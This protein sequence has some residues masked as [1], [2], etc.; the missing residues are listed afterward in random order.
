MLLN[1]PSFAPEISP[2]VEFGG[3]TDRHLSLALTMV[4]RGSVDSADLSA[5]SPENVN[6]PVLR[7]LIDTAWQREVGDVF[8]FDILSVA[9]TL[10]IVGDDKPDDDL[11]DDNGKP[12]LGLYI[13]CNMPESIMPGEA[14]EAV[15]AAMPGLGRAALEIIEQALQPFGMPFTVKG[16]YSMAQML[17]WYGEDSEELAMAEYGEDADIPTRDDLFGS[18]PQWAYDPKQSDARA[19]NESELKQAA[20]TLSAERF[21]PF[22][23]AI[24]ELSL[25]LKDSQRTKLL[26]AR[27]A[28]ASQDWD[29]EE[30]FCPPVACGWRDDDEGVMRL[31]DD[32]NEAMLNQ[33]EYCSWVCKIPVAP[34]FESISNTISDIRHTGLLLKQLDTALF[35]ASTLSDDIS[36]SRPN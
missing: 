20:A 22:L 27:Q 2:K 1:L 25:S 12:M 11:C 14:L 3:A 19:L 13:D 29:H 15:E 24:H 16:A 8:S 32:Y 18:I 23:K 4:K 31:F 17:H 33:G 21:G 10:V 28:G 30:T 36:N 5:L 26:M 9:A 6:V 35:L 7:R 34:T